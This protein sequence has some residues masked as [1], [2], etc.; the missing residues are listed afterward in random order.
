M[1]MR[2]GA[3]HQL[4]LRLEAGTLTLGEAFAF[5]SGLYFRGKLAYATA[6][7]GRGRQATFVIT[8]TRGLQ[9]PDL[10]ISRALID[11]FAGVDVSQDDERYRRPLLADARRLEG[12]LSPH[13]RIVLLGSVAT[14]KYLDVL[15]GVFGDRLS[16][17]SDF[18]G[19]GDMSRGALMLRAAAAGAELE[20]VALTQQTPRHGRRP[21][22][23]A[24]VL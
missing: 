20:Y 14:A 4:A 16:F 8:P 6:F 11:E 17:P 12:A 22:R 10:V 18:V 5:M 3:T 9:P 15:A 24:P 19:R 1:L 13:E 21:P 7:A 2:P 23:L